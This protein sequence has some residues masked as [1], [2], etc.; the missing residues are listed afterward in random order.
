MSYANNISVHSDTTAVWNG[1]AGSNEMKRTAKKVR[2]IQHCGTA[3]NLNVLG[4]PVGHQERDTNQLGSD[5]F[6][7]STLLEQSSSC[8]R[9][10]DSWLLSLSCAVPKASCRLSTV[11]PTRQRSSLQTTTEASTYCRTDVIF[12][13]LT[14]VNPEW[15]AQIEFGTGRTGSKNEELRNCASAANTVAS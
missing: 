9:C 14:M 15:A 6:K 2:V 4:V 10:P 3:Q 11:P 13:L 1:P 12:L 8:E 7:H 5:R